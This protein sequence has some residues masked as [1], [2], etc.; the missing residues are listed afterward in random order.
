MW[1]LTRL[2]N[3]LYI[4]EELRIF[5]CL[6]RSACSCYCPAM[7]CEDAAFFPYEIA[8]KNTSKA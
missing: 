5:T 8:T 1:H 4:E 7:R 3:E 2:F 6:V